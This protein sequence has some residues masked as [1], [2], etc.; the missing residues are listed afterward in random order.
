MPD[1]GL[2]DDLATER[3]RA[4]RLLLRSTLIDIAAD[5]DDFL[6]VARHAEWLID[7]FEATCGWRLTV[8]SAAGFARL[9]KR[10]ATI[11][12]TRPL[13]RP[14]GSSAPFDR[15]RY[16]LLCL[17]AAQLVQYPVTTIGT[18]ARAIQADAGFNSEL[19]RE[20]SAFV[21][22]LL[23]LQRWGAVAASAGRLD[24]FVDDPDGNALLQADTARLHRLLVGT[25]GPST[26]APD[27]T[28]GDSL[29]ALLNEPRYGDAA[30]RPDIDSDADPEAHIAGEAAPDDH[31][32][33]RRTPGSR[34]QSNDSEQFDDEQRVRWVRHTLGRRLADDPACH[35]DELTDPERR[36]IDHPSGRRWLRQQ[37]NAI[38]LHVEARAE[39][40]LAVDP[41]AIA[42]DSTFPGPHGNAAQLALLLIGELVVDVADEARFERREAVSLSR[43]QVVTFTNRILDRFPK[44]AKSHRVDDGPALLAADAIDL[45]AAHRLV[46]VHDD[47]AMTA[48][49]AIARYR[50][51]DPKERTDTGSTGPDAAA[52]QPDVLDLEFT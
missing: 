50:P 32:P 12:P 5:R 51:L 3:G 52:P 13:R 49:P 29:T 2:A 28:P 7:W 9:E 45:L 43:A 18:L 14:R 48:R 11:D 27:I 25:T 24:D 37:M 4:A 30:A 40:W 38:G 44:W 33:P 19:R 31:D 23:T 42:T 6:L 1:I 22:A 35:F 17:L 10:A 21:D 16:Q 36:Y 26:L 41:E 47:G 39:G 8:D 15:R 20:R 46:L 34:R